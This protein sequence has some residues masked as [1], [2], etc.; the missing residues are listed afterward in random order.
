[1]SIG[2]ENQKIVVVKTTLRRIKWIGKNCICK[3]VGIINLGTGSHPQLF[4]T[5]YGFRVVQ[6]D[7]CD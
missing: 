2:E 7:H 6:S 4:F 1:M 3:L 5:F